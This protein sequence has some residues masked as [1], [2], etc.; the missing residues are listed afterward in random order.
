MAAEPPPR[1][2]IAN[3]VLNER[4]SIG[5]SYGLV[6]A[7]LVCAAVPFVE[8]GRRIKPDWDGSYLLF[9]FGLFALE[10]LLS[11]R[12]SARFSFPSLEWA[13]FRLTE[14]VVLLAGLKLYL[15][16]HNGF[17]RLAVDLPL[18]RANFADFFDGEYV[19]AL[20]LAGAT[21]AMAS[22]FAGALVDLEG[23]DWLYARERDSMV[24]SDR[25]GARKRLSMD[26]FVVGGVMLFV[27]AILRNDLT[28]LGLPPPLFDTGLINVVLYFVL[29]LL[30]LAQSQFAILRA[31]WSLDRMPIAHNIAPGW[32]GYTLALLAV[33]A[34]LVIFLPTRYSVGLLDTLA[35]LLYVIQF[36]IFLILFLIWLPIRFLSSLFGR[37]PESPPAPPPDLTPVAP[38]AAGGASV[39]GFEVLKSILF[40]AILTGVVG[41]SIVY[42]VRQRADLLAA[43][44]KLPA[45]AWLARA[46]ARLSGNLRDL[47]A[48]ARGALAALVRRARPAR[49][50][51]PW[52]F[53][54][55]RRLSPREQVRFYYLA[56]VRR[57]DVPRRP[58][59]T[60]VEYQGQLSHLP[61]AD[62]S[63]LTDMFQEARYSAHP[64][65]VAQAGLAR[66][67]WENI[68]EA[69][70]RARGAAD[71]AAKT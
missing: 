60:P 65:S 44:A 22:Y 10:A 17:D 39:P 42:Y 59:Q 70:H 68:R 64:I 20:I 63:G 29:G 50:L 71:P 19:Y 61:A 48:R 18:W 40:W 43:L 55:L 27:T 4:T 35:F 13:A 26:I 6:T 8:L 3:L 45:F 47:N 66:K 12:A 9:A 34:A 23:D 15:Y 41:F 7:M 24:I 49:G 51:P 11:Q 57:A 54:S 16:S 53:V 33:C 30:L 38:G 62:V 69:L 2:P 36:L 5:L 25:G 58:S 28:F 67:Y 21:W 32:A 14:A 37:G 31:R 52:S 46:W 56:L 1:G